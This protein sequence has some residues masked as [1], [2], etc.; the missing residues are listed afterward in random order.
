MASTNL[1]AVATLQSAPERTCNTEVTIEGGTEARG[2]VADP[3]PRVEMFA[4]PAGMW[5]TSAVTVL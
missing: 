3:G 4:T 1:E 5:D 2:D